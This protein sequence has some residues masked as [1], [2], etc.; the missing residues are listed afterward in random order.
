VELGIPFSD[1]DQVRA[2][3]EISDGAVV[4]SAIVAEM[5]KIKNATEVPSRIGQLCRWLTG[6]GQ[7]IQAASLALRLLIRS[8]PLLHACIHPVSDRIYSVDLDVSPLIACVFC[9]GILSLVTVLGHPPIS[10]K[11]P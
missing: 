5:E 8:T 2:V 11:P 6:K 9:T 4:G 1:P 3:W 10:D 7:K